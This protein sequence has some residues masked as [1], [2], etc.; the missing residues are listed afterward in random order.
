MK[1]LEFLVV[2]IAALV[3]ALV[4]FLGRPFFGRS[5]AWIRLSILSAAC[6]YLSIIAGRWNGLGG[7]LLTPT[8][9]LVFFAVSLTMVS[10]S[11]FPIIKGVSWLRAA[12]ALASYL[13]NFHLTSYVVD[14]NRVV[15]DVRASMVPRW[16]T[17]VILV[18]V[19]NAVVLQTATMF[20][21][22][23]GPGINFLRR[24]ERIKTPVDLHTQIRTSQVKASTKDGVP[25]EAMVFCLFRIQPSTAT[26][27][28]DDFPWSGETVHRVVYGR[29]G[30]T[31][32]NTL[33][34]WDD[35]AL[36]VAVSRFREIM[37]RFRLDQLFA[38]TSPEQT[39]RLALASLLS[40]AVRNDLTQRG[41]ELVA[42][43]FGTLTF[44]DSVLEQ[45]IAT[46]QK[47]WAARAESTRA[48]GDAEAERIQRS[49]EAA[50]QWEMVQGLINGLS[51]A[52]GLAG[53]EPADLVTWQLLNAV[54][55][56]SADPLLQPHIP[57][58]TLD[59]MLAMRNWLE[60]QDLL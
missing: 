58:E 37:A 49:A 3:P 29:E 54:E 12:Q 4:L 11:L 47:E 48:I 30:T 35:Y 21:R 56:M 24:F 20:S 8:L 28:S 55:S 19:G 18:G 51:A 23:V 45:R 6:A 26:S 46:W 22:V 10:R 17:G 31:A 59:A 5:E 2:A 50:A 15:R 27:A 32:E 14:G 39:P 40:T 43:G 41:I 13:F 7:A 1:W 38:P 57:K 25:L 33:Y 16:G 53:I 60:E 44:P 36:Q 34:H 52:Q 9:A 42:A